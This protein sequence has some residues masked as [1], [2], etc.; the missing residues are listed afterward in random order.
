MK[1]ELKEV[2]DDPSETTNIRSFKTDPDEKG[3]ER[4]LGRSSRQK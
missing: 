1:R 2:V 3:T 4:D